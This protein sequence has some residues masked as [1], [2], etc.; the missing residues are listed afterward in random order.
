MLTLKNVSQGTTAA[1]LAV[2]LGVLPLAGCNAGGAGNAGETTSAE[3]TDEAAGSEAATDEATGDEAAAAADEKAAGPVWVIAK[4]VSS[5]GEGESAYKM[6]VAY[7]RDEQGNILT[8][9]QSEV[10]AE[11]EEPDSTL[12]YT[13]AYELDEDGYVTASFAADDETGDL[14]EEYTLKKDDEGNLL[15]RASADGDTGT[16]QKQT[17]GKDHKLL[18]REVSY[19]YV[20]SD[21]EG[22]EV[23]CPYKATITYGEDGYIEK[24]DIVDG[25]VKILGEY[26][27]EKNADGAVTKAV[28]REWQLDDGGSKIEDT[29]HEVNDA[30]E[31]DKNGNVARVTTKDGDQ[32]STNEYEWVKVDEPSLAARAEAAQPIV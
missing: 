25:D 18:T 14:R 5:F 15:E 21:A 12:A 11:G 3:T 7:E 2:M 26:E 24:V 16:T 17:F 28:Y 32:T 20:D 4:Q 22:N 30:V 19:S 13:E 10:P 27:Y 9:T 31:Y 6:Q 29:L 1:V 23:E 8:L